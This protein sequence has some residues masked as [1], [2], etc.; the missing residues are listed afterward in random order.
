MYRGEVCFLEAANFACLPEKHSLTTIMHIPISSSCAKYSAVT[1]QARLYVW[2]FIGLNQSSNGGATW[3]H[4]CLVKR[5]QAPLLLLLGK[6]HSWVP[7]QSFSHLPFLPGDSVVTW[8]RHLTVVGNQLRG[9]WWKTLVLNGA[10]SHMPFLLIAV[11]LS[12][13]DFWFA[14]SLSPRGYTQ[15]KT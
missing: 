2:P 13:P 1:N 3:W 15:Q 4:L 7:L 8:L 5:A 9:R 11:Q 10:S 12:N 14:T 6:S